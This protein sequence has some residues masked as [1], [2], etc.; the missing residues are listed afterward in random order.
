MSVPPI[1]AR[2]RPGRAPALPGQPPLSVAGRGAILIFVP[3][4]ANCRAL[5]RLWARRARQLA[6]FADHAGSRRMCVGLAGLIPAWGTVERG[7][8][9]GPSAMAMRNGETR[10]CRVCLPS[11]LTARPGISPAGPSAPASS[12]GASGAPQTVNWTR[13]RPEERL[14]AS[15]DR[16]PFMLL[17]TPPV[18]RTIAGA[19]SLGFP[20]FFSQSV[21]DL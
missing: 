9:C 13:K 20:R 1:T 4:R 10:P 7:V 17:A 2:G 8:H 16:A 6:V 19:V 12:S 18:K 5:T 11:A 14:R 15:S 21:R 3:D